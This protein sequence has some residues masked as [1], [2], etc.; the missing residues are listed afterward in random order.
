M[1]KSLGRFSL[2]ESVDE[3]SCLHR[4]ILGNLVPPH[5]RLAG[6]DFFPD[7]FP[8]LPPERSFAQHQLMGDYADCKVVHCIGMVLPAKDFGGHVSRCSAGIATIVSSVR[9]GDSKVSDM[10]VTLFIQDDVFGLYVSV[11][12]SF[13]MEV[14][15][16]EQ[17][18]DDEKFRLFL[19]EFLAGKV[20][21]EV[22][23]WKIVQ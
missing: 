9:S 18:T 17:N 2:N 3:V 6:Y 11:N 14:F 16:S 12:D 21:P 4:P 22:S 10:R 7:L 5:L 15:Q 13:A 20:I 8:G 19:T 1:A 23:S